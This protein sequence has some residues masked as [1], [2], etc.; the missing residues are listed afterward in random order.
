MPFMRRPVT[1][2]ARVTLTC[3]VPEATATWLTPSAECLDSTQECVVAAALG[4]ACRN[5]TA[6]HAW[7]ATTHPDVFAAVGVHSGL[8][9]GAARDMPSAFAA[10]ADALAGTAGNES[11]GSERHR[12]PE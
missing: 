3:T 1:P 8:A 9:C 5:D 12:A 4:L 6:C 2:P 10:M 7:L 11:A